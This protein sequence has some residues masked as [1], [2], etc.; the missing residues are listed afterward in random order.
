MF[1]REIIMG[2]FILSCCSTA[3][4]TKEHFEKRDINYICFHYELD[5][6]QYED[7]LG[8]S[9]SFDELYSKMRAGAETKTSQINVAEYKEYFE[10]FL[11]EGKDILHISLSSGVSGAYNSA[12]IAKNILEETFPERKIYIVDS[13]AGSSGSGLL[14]DKIADLH[15]E[16]KTMDE[17][18]E[19]VNENKLKMQHWLFSTD[20]TYFIKGGRISKTAGFVGSVLNICPILNVN[21]EGKIVPRHKVRTKK[22]VIEALVKQM[23]EN[24]EEGLDYSGKCYISHSG[25]YEDAKAVADLVESRFLKLDGKVE[26]NNIGTAIGCHAGPGTVGLFFWGRERMA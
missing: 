9:L 11:K 23:E 21:V 16:G 5:G 17:I 2:S 10:K 3:D 15:D 12:N 1:K 8:Q 20:L 14:M 18:Y 24:T 25:C 13:L 26:I 7:D 22:K 19:W 4:L 6:K